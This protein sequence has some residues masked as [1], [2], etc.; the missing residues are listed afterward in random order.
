MKMKTHI[1]R[2]QYSILKTRTL[3]KLWKQLRI[4]LRIIQGFMKWYEPD[5]RLYN[6]PGDCSGVLQMFCV[7]QRFSSFQGL[8]LCSARRVKRNGS[9]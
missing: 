3:I 6:R 7:N 9:L 1:T 2:F 5:N 8:L 4:I